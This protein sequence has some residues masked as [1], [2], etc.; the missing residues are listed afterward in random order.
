MTDCVSRLLATSESKQVNRIAV[1]AVYFPLR[2]DFARVRTHNQPFHE[3]VRPSAALDRRKKS[4]ACYVRTLRWDVGLNLKQRSEP[5][6]K[7]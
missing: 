2:L 7:Q 4:E 5:L 6:S 1:V 3:S